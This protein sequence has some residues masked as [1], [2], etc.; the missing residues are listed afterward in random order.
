MN[1][2]EKNDINIQKCLTSSFN[3][4]KISNNK[5]YNENNKKNYN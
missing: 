4:A 5:S 3:R 2:N 1:E